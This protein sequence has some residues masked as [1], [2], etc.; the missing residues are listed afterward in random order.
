MNGMSVP[1]RRRPVRIA[2]HLRTPLGYRLDDGTPVMWDSK[3]AIDGHMLISGPSGTG[4]TF[5]LNRLIATLAQGVPR[6]S[7]S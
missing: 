3:Q 4:K 5:Q 1:Q 6:A 2:P 7:T